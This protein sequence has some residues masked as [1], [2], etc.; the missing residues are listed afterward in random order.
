MKKFLLL[1]LTVALWGFSLQ[2]EAKNDKVKYGKYIYRVKLRTMCP[3]D[4]E[5]WW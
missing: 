1:F 5:P 3:M 4:K 2:A